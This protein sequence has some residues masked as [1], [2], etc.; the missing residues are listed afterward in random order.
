MRKQTTLL[1]MVML[2]I[3][4]IYPTIISEA[5]EVNIRFGDISAPVAMLTHTFYEEYHSGYLLSP[6]YEWP[7]A[8]TIQ[9]KSIPYSDV[10]IWVRD[11]IEGWIKRV[12]K[13]K[14]IP[15]DFQKKIILIKDEI[16]GYDFARLRYTIENKYVV[17]ISQ[18]INVI[19]VAVRPINT[20]AEMTIFS[21]AKNYIQ[22]IVEDL[23][24]EE[25]KIKE[26]TLKNLQDIPQGFQAQSIPPNFL[27]WW[28]RTSIYSDGVGV[29]FTIGKGYGGKVE[30]FATKEWFRIES[31]GAS[32]PKLKG[33]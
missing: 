31:F 7:T 30:S 26:I 13:E 25:D 24:N 11:Q 32:G 22:K 14:Y 6:L 15:P 10:S 19:Y 23:F 3:S 27:W 29:G 20:V 8:E 21:E 18:N 2:S 5:E 9:S 4:T 17:H 1:F 12:I 28:G 33:E 16:N